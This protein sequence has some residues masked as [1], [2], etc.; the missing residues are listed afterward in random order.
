MTVFKGEK[1]HKFWAISRFPTEIKEDFKKVCKK[2]EKQLLAALR[3]IM[4]DYVNETEELIK[5]RTTR[6]PL[7]RQL[8]D[9]DEYKFWGVN[10]FPVKLQAD[11]KSSC[12][13]RG[14]LMVD[15]LIF[16]IKEYVKNG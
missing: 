9:F 15:A 3:G 5:S 12:I 11:F 14:D 7:P 2:Q 8:N 6:R 10:N 1:T 4:R 16:K 13:L